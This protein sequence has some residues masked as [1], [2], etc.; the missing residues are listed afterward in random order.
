MLTYSATDELIIGSCCMGNRLSGLSTV[1][2]MSW[3]QDHAVWETDCLAWVQSDWW[4]DHR[5]ML[6]GKQ[7]VWPEYSLTYEL[8]TGSCCM[9]NRLS[10]LSTVWLMSWSQDHAVWETDCLAW[11]QSD[12]WTDH[13]IM[14]YGKQTV[15]PEYSLTDE[16]IT[17]PCCMGNRLAW[18]QSDWWADHR[19]MLYGKQTVWPEYSLTDELITG[20]CCMGNRLFGLALVQSD[21]RADHRIMLYGKQTV[22]PG[23]STVWLMSWSQDHAVWETDCLAL[24]Q[25]DWRA[26]HRII[27]YGK[28]TVWPGLSTVW[29]MNWSQD[30]AVWEADCL[31]WTGS[32]AQT[33]SQTMKIEVVLKLE[34]FLDMSQALVW[35]HT[36][37][38]I[39]CCEPCWPNRTDHIWSFQCLGLSH[40]VQK[41]W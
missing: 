15:W 22:W 5:I 40:T 31:A 32:R 1:W 19:V 17:G 39:A 37:C 38:S 33:L 21:W 16:L 3:S 29:L 36:A 14:L 4:A 25:S 6:Y 18:V 12:W 10:G 28:Q 23:L 35:C 26:D 7:T 13:R 27:L 11:V 8:I 2:L 24:V 34:M 9:G 20:S 30:H 41:T